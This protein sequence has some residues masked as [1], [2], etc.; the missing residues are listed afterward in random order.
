MRASAI[1]VCLLLGCLFVSVP[2]FGT[3]NCSSAP[4]PGSY[5]GYS[6]QEYIIN[7]L[8]DSDTSCWYV[9]SFVTAATLSSC[10]STQA[11]WEFTSST[12]GALIR[13]VNVGVND[14]GSSN[15]V[16]GFELDFVDPNSSS[17]D[18]INV[19]VVVKH[20]GV[21]STVAS[22]YHDGSQGTTYCSQQSLSFNA[23]N[24]DEIKIYLTGARSYSTAHIKVARASLWRYD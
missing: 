6:W 24:G 23:V 16:F 11:G 13:T 21:S 22:Y 4:T 20:G 18:Y 8:I 17:Y 15:W 2:A 10:S 9:N 12:L 5:Y 14:T 7:P 19:S 1:A 3:Y